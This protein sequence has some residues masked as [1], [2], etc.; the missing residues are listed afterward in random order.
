MLRR[1]VFGFAL[2]TAAC[3]TPVPLGGLQDDDRALWERCKPAIEANACDLPASA[4]REDCLEKQALAYAERP[5]DRAKRRWLSAHGCPAA[6]I[7]GAATPTARQ[8]PSAPVPK[9]APQPH[10]PSAAPPARLLVSGPVMS[11]PVVPASEGT[12]RVEP[13]APLLPLSAQCL[14]SADCQSDL[15][16][17]ARCVSEASLV[18]AAS[19][20]PATLV[21]EEQ[22]T[23][24]VL[25]EPSPLPPAPPLKDASSA[26]PLRAGDPGRQ[27]RD[28]LAGY[29]TDM[30]RC[31]E[32]QLKLSPELRAQG[33]LVI[34]VDPRGKVP[35]VGLRGKPL[36]GSALETCLL[37]V[38]QRWRFPSTGRAYRVEAPI[39]ISGR[40]G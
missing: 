4:S 8:Q 38:A 37:I 25:V 23:A 6:V 19:L 13:R 18:V 29:E 26:P 12:V 17:K 16:Y 28:V 2:L 3:S 35:K 32:R 34:E 7:E 39:V 20:Q 27:L 5:H 31:V 14:R 9:K 24:A 15:C 21:A 10:G 36:S 33:T 1:F 22:S 40:A 30:Q 11:V